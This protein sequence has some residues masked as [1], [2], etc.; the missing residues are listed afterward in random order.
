MN[1]K[2]RF[3]DTEQW[4]SN[5][6]FTE[7]VS[8]AQLLHIYMYLDRADF[9]GIAYLDL[10]AA[11]HSTKL[12]DQLPKDMN[13][14]AKVLERFWVHYGCGIFI[15]KNF[16]VKTQAK[17][18][19]LSNPPHGAIIKDMA[20]WHNEGFEDVFVEVMKANK[21]ARFVPLQECYDSLVGSLAGAKAKGN[22]SAIAGAKGRLKNFEDVLIY[23]ETICP[24]NSRQEFELNERVAKQFGL[25]YEAAPALENRVEEQVQEEELVEEE[26]DPLRPNKDPDQSKPK[27]LHLSQEDHDLKLADGLYMQTDGLYKYPLNP[28]KDEEVKEEEEDVGQW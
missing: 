16:L 1:R 26:D 12:K 25:S 3:I 20:C 21:T 23:L 7:L 11:G 24:L 4:R 15:H 6:H 5:R 2:S 18:I 28:F 10:E 27:L 19:N 14:I 17:R 13:E 22:E 9:A 8:W